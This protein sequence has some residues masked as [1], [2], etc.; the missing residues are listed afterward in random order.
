MWHTCATPGV[1]HLCYPGGTC[2]LPPLHVCATLPMQKTPTNGSLSPSRSK[3][4]RLSE[5]SPLAGN[6][7]L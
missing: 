6:L 7:T 3:A 4:R 1:A 5:H 2:V